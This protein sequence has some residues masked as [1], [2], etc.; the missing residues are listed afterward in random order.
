MTPKRLTDTAAIEHRLLDLAYTT[1][2]TITASSLA[3]FAPCS[4]EDA[5]KVLSD[6]A[7][8]DRIRMDVDDNGTISYHVPDRHKLRP[9]VE[10][11][12]P[13]RD[14]LALIRQVEPTALVRART[15]SPL[16]AAAL[17]MFLPGAGQLYTGRFL[18][19]VLWFMVV[20]AG[21]A[22]IIPG[23]ILH[24][25]CILSAASSANQ[26]NHAVSRMQLAA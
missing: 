15:A 16:L 8:R 23:L 19:A 18:A 13:P 22:L 12:P 7:A 14:N 11:L 2:A 26:L 24:F 10:R 17:S 25:F 5:D 9:A 1:D 20:G 6:L 3:Y 4:F 21:Y